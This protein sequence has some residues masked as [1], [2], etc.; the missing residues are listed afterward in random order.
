MTQTLPQPR[1]LQAR[2]LSKDRVSADVVRLRLLPAPG[3]RFSHLPGQYLRLYLGAFEPRDYSIASLPREDALEFHIRDQGEGGASSYVANSL[4]VGDA[5]QIEGP[6]GS[7]VLRSGHEGPLIGVAGGTGLAPVLAILRQALEA[8]HPAPVQLCYGTARRA[9]LFQENDLREIQE[10]SDNF[11]LFLSL[12]E[13]NAE[14]FSKG[15][16]TDL[17]TPDRLHLADARAFVAGP[18]AMTEAAVRRL[19]QLGLH[20]ERI[21]ADAFTLGPA[22]PQESDG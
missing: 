2:V 17:L 5:L 6:F 13:E 14:G 16:V 8:G 7:C 9:D 10:S 3:E 4:A 18:P 1:K 20:E 22:L 15:L 11:E 19:T 12:A 21:H